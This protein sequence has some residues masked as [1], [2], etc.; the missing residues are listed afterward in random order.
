M[1]GGIWLAR[2]PGAV[3]GGLGARVG[4][5]SGAYCCH[6]PRGTGTICG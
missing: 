3:V 2:L 4:W 6:L 1:D 5:L